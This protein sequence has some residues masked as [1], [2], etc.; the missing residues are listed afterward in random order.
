[1]KMRSIALFI[2]A[3]LLSLPTLAADLQAAADDV[4]SC[5]EAPY[6][7]V[8]RALDDLQKAQAS[9]DYSK[10]TQAQGEMMG[11]MSASS[12]CFAEL[13]AKYPEIEQ[14]DELKSKV[15]ALADKQCP[16]PAASYA[17]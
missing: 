15:M 11:V 4:C 14:N 10:M 16:N 6:N 3:T 1:M 12:K 13:P 9:G 17:Q 5:L 2:L 8:Q 7:V